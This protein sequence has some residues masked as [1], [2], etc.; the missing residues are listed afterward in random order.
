MGDHATAVQL[1]NQGVKS[2][3]DRS[4]PSY[5]QHA[6]QQFC[7]AMNADPEWATAA[8]QCGNNASDLNHFQAAIACWRRALECE[9]PDITPL[10]VQDASRAKVLCNLGW[11]LESLGYTEEAL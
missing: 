9:M 2:A 1:Y 8:Y 11:R 10:D 3:A 5:L 6:F 4:S 7:S